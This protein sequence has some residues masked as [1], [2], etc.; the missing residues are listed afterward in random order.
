MKS[1][2]K[3]AAAVA[4]L[5]MAVAAAAPSMAFAGEAGGIAAILP[6]WNEFIPMLVAFIIILIVLGKFGWPIFENIL[7]KREE[8]IKESLEKSEEA[9]IE[10]ERVLEE[11]KQQL[12]QARQE[13]SAIIAEAKQT[14]ETVRAEIT[15]KAQ[16][17]AEEI[18]SKAREAIETEKKAAIADLQGS[19]ADLTVAVTAKVIGEDFSDDDHRKLIERCVAEAGSID[20]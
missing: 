15:A 13:A 10:S 4:G 17:E 5:S 1:G 20:G 8:T 14:G 9:R 16:V 12:T 18:V 2:F 19:V 11:Y 3:K 7:T 6:D